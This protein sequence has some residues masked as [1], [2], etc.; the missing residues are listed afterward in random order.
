MRNE[1]LQKK[2]EALFLSSKQ[3]LIWYLSHG[4][5]WKYLMK[6]WAAIR[7][8][9]FLGAA[10]VQSLLIP[11]VLLQF[12]LLFILFFLIYVFNFFETSLKWKI[13]GQKLSS[14]FLYLGCNRSNIINFRSITLYAAFLAMDFCLIQAIK[15]K[16]T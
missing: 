13:W 8:L 4:C 10:V 3:N 2:N 9:R 11:K 1:N 6:I 7:F 15:W 12:L 5:L 14:Y 16:S